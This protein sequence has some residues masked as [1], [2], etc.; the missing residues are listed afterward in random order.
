L[1]GAAVFD[2]RLPIA[3]GGQCESQSLKKVVTIG[4]YSIL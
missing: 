2:G 1:V 3:G 4:V